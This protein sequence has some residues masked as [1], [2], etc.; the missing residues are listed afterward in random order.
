[1]HIVIVF[2]KAPIYLFYFAIYCTQETNT[3][4]KTTN[5]R[6]HNRNYLSLN[7]MSYSRP[8]KRDDGR[9]MEF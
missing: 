6:R 5:N 8:R 9:M 2:S 4:K 3:G 7:K 1:M